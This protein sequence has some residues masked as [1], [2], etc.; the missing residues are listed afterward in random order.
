CGESGRREG[1]SLR[2]VLASLD[3]GAWFGAAAFAGTLGPQ[4]G[5]F[6]PLRFVQPE[7][8]DWNHRPPAQVQPLPAARIVRQRGG[9]ERWRWVV[10]HI[11]RALSGV[12]HSLHHRPEPGLR[13]LA[14]VVHLHTPISARLDPGSTVADVAAAL[15]PTPAVAGVPSQAAL[16]FIAEHEGIDRG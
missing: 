4:W 15:H 16:R 1:A 3:S 9:P 13:M 11:V 10:E 5:G 8:I 12:A 14:N 2:E 6:V 7:R